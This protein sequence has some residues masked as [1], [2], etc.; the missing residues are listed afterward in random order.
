MLQF[1]DKDKKQI[2]ANREP[3]NDTEEYSVVVVE[4]DDEQTRLNP[5]EPN[6][7]HRFVLMDLSIVGG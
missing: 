7:L 2:M 4:L 5:L 6:L 1:L 3:R